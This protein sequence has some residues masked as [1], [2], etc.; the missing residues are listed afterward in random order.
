MTS[1]EQ[2]DAFN[3]DLQ[4]LI[5]R[6]TNE[7]DLTLADAIGV[8]EVVK[9]SLILQQFENVDDDETE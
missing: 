6:Y 1:Q 2:Q 4:A 9:F 5:L 7:F 8:I 3:N